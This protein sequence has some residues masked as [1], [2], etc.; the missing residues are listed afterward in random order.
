MD[1][2]S[3]PTENEAKINEL[4]G[5]NNRE[6]GAWASGL[7]GRIIIY[8]EPN[9]N[10]NQTIEKQYIVMRSNFLRVCV[11]YWIGSLEVN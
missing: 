2:A 3:L 4:R 9:K 11:M 10:L 7:V 8:I 6:D 5:N 1:I